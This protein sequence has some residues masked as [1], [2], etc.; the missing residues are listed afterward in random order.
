MLGCFQGNTKIVGLMLATRADMNIIDYKGRSAL[1]WAS[2]KGHRE[3]VKKLLAWGA[4]ATIKDIKGRTALDHATANGH[5]R[6]AKLLR[7]I[8]K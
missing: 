3:A 1:I 5:M 7:L 8:W 2:A 6:I 4:N